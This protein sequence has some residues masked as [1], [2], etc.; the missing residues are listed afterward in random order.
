M[1][2]EIVIKNLS[3]KLKAIIKNVHINVAFIDSDDLYQEVILHLWEKYNQ[4]ELLN[5]TE[6]YVLQGC[7]YFIKNYL[8]TRYK[9]IDHYIQ[10]IHV[11]NDELGDSWEKKR[12][13]FM[14][15]SLC[16]FSETEILTKDIFNLLDKREQDVFSLSLLGLTKREIGSHLS[17]SHVM[18]IKIEKR[19]RNKCETIMREILLN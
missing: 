10:S 19:I 12:Y 17:I 8:R 6:S 1:E 3:V 7:F 18:V 13:H 5:K 15:T 9:K 16:D 2:F 11:L 4:N 14:N